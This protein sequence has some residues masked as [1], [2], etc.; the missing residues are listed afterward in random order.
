MVTSTSLYPAE[1][2]VLASLTNVPGL[3]ETAMIFSGLSPAGKAASRALCAAA[4]AR[5]GSKTTALKPVFGSNF[6]IGNHV[7]VDG[8]AETLQQTLGRIDSQ[9]PVGRIAGQ[10]I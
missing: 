6:N 8:T 5:G 10:R 7:F 4:P 1:T 3:Q 2:S 9:N